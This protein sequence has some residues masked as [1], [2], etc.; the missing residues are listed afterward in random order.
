MHHI[1]NSMGVCSLPTWVVNMIHPSLLLT[2]PY[3]YLQQYLLCWC[4][5]IPPHKSKSY[6]KDQFY[7][8]CMILNPK[9]IVALQLVP[10]LREKIG[11]FRILPVVEKQMWHNRSELWCAV[12]KQ[13]WNNRSGVIPRG[14]NLWKNFYCPYLS[15]YFINCKPWHIKVEF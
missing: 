9:L 14:V 11:Q 15:H 4:P 3:S 10:V 1:L 12:E 8:E 6:P 5:N 13:M 2:N 7:W